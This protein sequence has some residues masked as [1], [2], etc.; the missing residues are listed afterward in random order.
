MQAWAAG[1]RGSSTTTSTSPAVSRALDLCHRV[2]L[3]CTLR[4]AQRRE[5][6]PGQLVAAR[7]DQLALRPACVGQ[8]DGTDPFVRRV[9]L[10]DDEAVRL[11][12]ANEPAEV[13]RVQVE[14]AAQGAQVRRAVPDLPQ[15]AR[16]AE[17]PPPAEVLVVQHAQALG[18]GA[19]ERA[20]LPDR[21]R[22]HSLILV[23]DRGSGYGRRG[24]ADAG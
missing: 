14:P 1:L 5:Q 15:H 7:V 23:R 2:D 22:L 19:V 13:A 17:W 21:R 6:G 3:A 9:R 4:V 18:D 12:R 8:A 20:D 24:S 16:G 10:D 11:E